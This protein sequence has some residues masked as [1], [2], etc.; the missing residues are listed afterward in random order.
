MRT[1][2]AV[3]GVVT[4]ILALSSCSHHSATKADDK[5]TAGPSVAVSTSPYQ[6]LSDPSGLIKNGEAPLGG[7]AGKGDSKFSLVKLPADASHLIV[8]WDCDGTGV[9]EYYLDGVLYSSSPCATNVV[10]TADLPLKKAKI[11]PKVLTIKAPAD[12]YWKIAITQVSGQAS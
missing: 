6:L 9:F 10:A 11:H 2:L 5:A 1:P 7:G 3:A 8:R 12:V 4:A